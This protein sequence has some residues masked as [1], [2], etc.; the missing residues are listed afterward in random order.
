MA[1][2]E[3]NEGVPQ[4]KA[5]K[6]RVDSSGEHSMR[7]GFQIDER[8]ISLP[9]S[10][11]GKSLGLSVDVQL[12]LQQ[13]VNR[14]ENGERNIMFEVSC[15]KTQINKLVKTGVSVNV[16]DQYQ[17]EVTATKDDGEVIRYPF[18]SRIIAKGAEFLIEL[19]YMPDGY[20]WDGDLGFRMSIDGGSVGGK[21]EL[22]DVDVRRLAYLLTA[23][24][25]IKAAKRYMMIAGNMH[26]SFVE[27]YDSTVAPVLQDMREGMA[28]AALFTL[29]AVFDYNEKPPFPALDVQKFRAKFDDQK[30]YGTYRDLRNTYLAHLKPSDTQRMIPI[31]AF[32]ILGES[33]SGDQGWGWLPNPLPFVFGEREMLEVAHLLTDAERYIEEELAAENERVNESLAKGN[34]Q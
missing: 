6:E 31:H 10:D 13:V 19:R 8:S 24:D 7:K 17:A 30:A 18:M 28:S 33:G 14:I 4:A 20:D 12:F 16:G 27:Q 34:Q 29:I 25:R 3:L 5:N 9:T 2:H 21:I 11:D 15:D 22:I 32:R 1:D 23:R 26:R